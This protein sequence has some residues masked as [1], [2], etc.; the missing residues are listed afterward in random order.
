MAETFLL[1]VFCLLLIAAAAISVATK[2]LE[3][4]RSERDQLEGEIASLAREKER[5]VSENEHWTDH[6]DGLL[7]VA[8]VGRN[9]P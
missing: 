4:V 1:L 6:G 8:P 3:S 5:I 7:T 2:N 9:M